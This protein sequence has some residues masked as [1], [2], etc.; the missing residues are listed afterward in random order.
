[1][2]ADQMVVLANERV[3]AGVEL[4][5]FYMARREIPPDR[6]LVVPMP[7]GETIS[8]SDFEHR[9]A[10]P[11][12]RFL[13]NLETDGKGRVRGMAT[14]YGVPLRV[15]APPEVGPDA[16]RIRTL[17]AEIR[18]LREI[19]ESGG[20]DAESRERLRRLEKERHRLRQRT[21]GEAAVDSE[22]SL[23]RRERHPL[24]GWLRNPLYP[25]FRGR[26]AAVDPDRMLLVARLDG[27]T[28]DLIRRRLT[29]AQAAEAHGLRGVAYFD[30]RWPESADHADGYRAFDLR[31]HRAA[32]GLKR[33]GWPVVLETTEALFGPGEAPEA[34]LYC[35][36]Y[37]L[38]RYA[39]AFDWTPGAVAYHV[40]SGECATLRTGGR[41][42]WCLGLL[43]DG[44]AAVIGPVSEPFLT[45]FPPPDLFFHKLEAEKRTL[46]EAYWESLPYLSWK[47]VLVGDPLYR[48]FAAKK[49]PPLETLFP[50]G[51]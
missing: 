3:P 39:D 48:P 18:R 24:G 34:A 38:S 11:L 7:V 10:A 47:M 22:L 4:A 15:T 41:T 28:P 14:V 46:A 1:M 32:A 27:P 35:G 20:E 9:V 40:A 50:G 13:E 29:E 21:D 44:A 16:E 8:R 6:L 19:R 5:R 31:L 43:M 23:V 2:S 42:P 51:K 45:A 37:R 49:N 36:W 26:I 33:R 12:R 30:A 25:G 17:E